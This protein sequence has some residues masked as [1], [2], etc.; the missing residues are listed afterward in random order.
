[1]SYAADHA[2]ALADIRESGAAVSFSVRNPGVPDPLTGLS[3]GGG[4]SSVA[5]HGLQLPGNQERY[6]DLQLVSFMAI[7][8]LFAASTY[9]EK[10]AIGSTFD[11]MG[12]TW[13]VKAIDPFAPDGTPVIFTVIGGR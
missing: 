9:G 5:G 4:T 10:P 12:S 13:T 6:R 3:T 2:S 1:M 8:L 7:T 11:F